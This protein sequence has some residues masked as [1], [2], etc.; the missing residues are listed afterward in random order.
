MSEQQ[1][2][3]EATY[4]FPASYAQQ[5]MWLLDRLEPGNV[6]YNIPLGFRITGKLNQEVLEK[7]LNEI[8]RRHETLRTAFD[9]E[10]GELMQVIRAEA[11]LSLRAEEVPGATATQ[12][13]RRVE[14]IASQEAATVFDL[15]KWPLIRARLLKVAAQ[16]HVLILTMHH[17]ITDGWSVGVLLKELGSLYDSYNSGQQ[18]A[19]EELQVQYADYAHWQRQWLESG[20]LE[21][22]MQY[23]RERMRGAPPVLEMPTDYARPAVQS[24]RGSSENLVITREVTQ[25][26]KHLGRQEGVT[27]FMSL[28]GAF[29]VLLSRYSGQEDI[30]VGTP[31]AN[32]RRAEL[33]GLIGCFANTLVMRLAVD[34]KESFRQ[35]LERVREV[36]LEAYAN[37]DVPF[38]KLVEELQP[39]R[40]FSRSP[41]FQAIFMFRSEP[42]VELRIGDLKL[43]NEEIF[44]DATKY[45]ISLGLVEEDGSLRGAIA[46]YTD[47]YKASTIRRMARRFERLIESTVEDP[48][49]SIRQLD[50]L[51]PS[52]SQQILRE[53]NDTATDYPRDC[54][55]HEL[56]EQ[57]ARLTPDAVAVVC[58]TE[59]LTYRELNERANQLA[60]HL[61]DAGAGP[62][63]I[64][65]I[66]LRRH[67]ELVVSLL[68]VLKSG[69]AYLPL[70]PAYPKQRLMF[71]MEDAEMKV[72]VTQQEMRK[73]LAGRGVRQ[74]EVDAHREQIGAR[75][76]YNPSRTAGAGNLAYVIY[77]S[78]STGNP[79]GVAIG[80]SSLATFLFWARSFFSD[81][82][83]GTVLA[84]TSICFDISVIEI[85]FPIAFGGT[86]VLV[87]NAL[88]L[89]QD[90]GENKITFLNTVSSVLREL[91]ELAAVP[92]SV[93]TVGFA[94]EAVP[95]DLKNKVCELP[96][97]KRVCDLYGPTEDTVYSTVS[98]LSMDEDITIGRP[99]WH[100]RAYIRGDQLELCP[101]AVI[102]ELMLSGEGL[103]RGYVGRGDLTAEKFIPDPDSKTGGERMYR[104]GDA[105]R[106]RED[107]KIEY[108]GRRD[109]QVKIRGHRIELA[110]IEAALG[111]H[112]SVRQAAV[113]VKQDLSAGLT[114]VAYVVAD[115]EVSTNQLKD[116]LRQ[117]LP[118]YMLPTLIV[119]LERMPLTPN[120]KLDRKNLPEAELEA[121]TR[122][123]Q[124][125]GSEL[126]RALAHIWGQVL[127]R[128]AIGVTENFFE[129][130]GHSLLATQVLSRLRKQMGLD[131]PLQALFKGPTVRELARVVEQIK[132]NGAESSM[133]AMRPIARRIIPAR[134]DSDRPEK[135]DGEIS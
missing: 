123:Y 62:E 118:E 20:E 39:E 112:P 12:K 15:G 126:E 59:S 27:L 24:Y 31:I 85:F 75:S 36:S 74:I 5:R 129:L 40:D 91:L 66:C 35:F 105:A 104:T 114:L 57:Q 58:Q 14:E 49:C 121:D 88:Q 84:S 55:I 17:I 78:G 61:L 96:F 53:W 41:I 19:L 48:D 106:W 8:I 6:T 51:S 21:R 68:A 131:V 107:G 28:L 111:Q 25:K 16:E 90:N 64:V 22:Q 81:D 33:D 113:A 10:A 135:S 37:Q 9:E 127:K 72:L 95:R 92:E 47:L 116:S 29:G 52:E 23:W 60:H 120:A 4:V 46:Y 63:V 132:R 44:Y 87:E 134:E 101:V 86:S 108:L 1:I 11:R 7:S 99:I 34:G 124:A 71:M 67:I 18:P 110:E 109:E 69:A 133:P 70:D 97:V 76:K 115:D 13:Q 79:K 125:P 102:G 122:Q 82:E 30:V 89:A 119:R 77:T 130:G 32:R 54:L 83:L 45:E 94:G 42:Q 73:I 117:K 56:F 38:E 3:P 128:G 43:Q 26:L 93:R 50:L 2:N 103:A 100:T 80:H 98:E 65:G